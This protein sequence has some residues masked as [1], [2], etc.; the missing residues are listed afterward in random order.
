MTIL[1]I[2]LIGGA[3]GLY[4]KDSQSSQK[5]EITKISPNSLTNG[6][7]NWPLDV[8]GLQSNT[9]PPALDG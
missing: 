6:N 9:V 2:G 4:Y 5:L 1:G 7:K 3:G 8:N